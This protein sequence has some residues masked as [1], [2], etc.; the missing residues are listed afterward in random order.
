MPTAGDQIQSLS[1]AGFKSLRDR[2]EIRIRPI[3][4]LAGPN[5]SG[6]SS[7]MQPFLLIKQ[8]QE[9]Q[10]N[11]GPLL[12]SGPQ[13]EFENYRELFW[14]NGV[15]SNPPVFRV[16]LKVDDRIGSE[17]SY[18]LERKGDGTQNEIALAE[19]RLFFDKPYAFR[20][21]KLVALRELPEGVAKAYRRR[22]KNALPSTRLEVVARKGF[23]VY[24]EAA[25][26]KDDQLPLGSLERHGLVGGELAWYPMLGL[27]EL[28]RD[29][30]HLPGLRGNPARQ[31]DLAFPGVQ[32][33]R[34]TRYPGSFLTY[35]AGLLYEWTNSVDAIN[36]EKILQLNG[37]LR[38]LGFT[39]GLRVKRVSDTAAEIEVQRVMTDD[40]DFL[41]MVKIADV[42][43][44]LSQ[45]LPIL[46]AL[47]AASGSSLVH[48]EQ[49]EIHLH[50]RAQYDLA[51]IIA[52]TV[53]N[54]HARVVIETHSP[55]LILGFQTLV[56]QEK[57]RASDVGLNWF[58][59]DE[60]GAT[61][62]TA[63]E[64]DKRGRFGDWPVD[65]DEISLFAQGE[66]MTAQKEYLK[67]HK[68]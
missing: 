57:L 58:S 67:K 61:T 51:K 26:P 16:G 45:T 4:I 66:Y 5:S 9:E 42:G 1:V 40:P 35:V 19:S 39:S 24:R 23:I 32:N 27:D 53:E 14:R 2:Q 3:T 33:K 60:Q 22:R 63:T 20:C 34:H 8:T 48:I 44:G 56:A 36:P 46:V 65:F 68:S 37:Y 52:N 13:V 10:V 62:V 64:L 49:P 38:Q 59:R 6:K 41:D 43:L 18:E 28:V 47:L 54:S 12:L 17:Q 55:L 31:Y 21:G 30:V 11:Y 15:D 29:M 25:P 50:P 7:F